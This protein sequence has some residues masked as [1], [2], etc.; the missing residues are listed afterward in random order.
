VDESALNTQDISV[1]MKHRALSG[2]GMQVGKLFISNSA[3]FFI[4]LLF[5]FLSSFTGCGK[6]LLLKY[7][8]C[9]VYEDIFVLSPR[10]LIIFSWQNLLLM[11]WLPSNLWLQFQCS[12]MQANALVVAEE[13]DLKAL[14]KWISRIL[15]CAMQQRDWWLTGSNS[16]SLWNKDTLDTG[17]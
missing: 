4:Y 5:V 11:K 7:R 8:N 15:H 12:D 13:P 3:I 1:I 6:Y 17:H 9:Y 14:W 2:Y 10:I 16:D